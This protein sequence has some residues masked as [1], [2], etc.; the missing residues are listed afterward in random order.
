MDN[1]RCG[2]YFVW[3]LQV[4]RAKIYVCYD[5]ALEPDKCC[6]NQIKLLKKKCTIFS[7]F[8]I[9]WFSFECAHLLLLFESHLRCVSRI[10]TK[11]LFYVVIPATMVDRDR[12]TNTHAAG[13]LWDN[14]RVCERCLFCRVQA[15]G[16]MLLNCTVSLSLF[17][18][19]GSSNR[20]PV[21][22]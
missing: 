13:T 16:K 3:N 22:Q 1:C 18:S 14:N 4:Q 15:Y 7:R 20:K 8:V 5:N 19:S 21:R 2:T 11:N 12:R 17:H 10:I 6:Y 9:V